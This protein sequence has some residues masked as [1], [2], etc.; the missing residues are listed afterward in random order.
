MAET[1]FTTVKDIYDNRALVAA[2]EASIKAGAVQRLLS[3]LGWNPFDVGEVKPEY[4]VGA[5][6]ID[7]SLRVKGAN[8]VFIEVASPGE[9]LEACQERLLR[10]ALQEGVKL[11]LLTNGSA[12]WFYLPLNEGSSEQRRFL[13]ADLT[14]KEIEP[15]AKRFIDLLLKK[16]VA[17]GNALRNAEHL[18]RDSRRE[19]AVKE[20]LPK[21]WQKMITDPDNLLVGL[22]METTERLSGFRPETAEVEKFLRE[23][24]SSSAPQPD[25]A[26]APEGSRAEQKI[27][28]SFVENYT[29]KEV[30]SFTLLGRTSAPVNWKELLIAV[31]E[32]MHRRHAGSF[33]KC[34]ALGGTETAYFRRSAEGLN[35]P[36]QIPDS[37]YFV[38]TKLNSNAI[39]R[40]SRELIA[41]FG[42]EKSDL[43]IVAE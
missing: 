17:S 18:Y 12:W 4:A 36:V 3:L 35:Q 23:V 40:L 43:T 19:H 30:R 20:A 28:P 16:N 34:L 39:V 9:S 42:H 38:E 1:I 6:R 29:N 11:A 15:L 10:C 24:S 31:S 32:E 37:A 25:A 41:L 26:P 5:E 2:D 7:F 33:D 21:A 27:P 22:L 14:E 13:A 8:E